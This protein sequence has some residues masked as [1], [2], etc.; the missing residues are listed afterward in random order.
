MGLPRLKAGPSVTLSSRKDPLQLKDTINSLGAGA[1]TATTSEAAKADI[2]IL[3]LPWAELNSLDKLT[4]WKN[5][6]VID[7]TNH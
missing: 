3:A 4:D 5:K 7:A 6:I 2:V 1:K